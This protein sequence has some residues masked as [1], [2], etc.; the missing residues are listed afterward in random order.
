MLRCYLN[1]LLTVYSVSK[2]HFI[3]SKEPII[4]LKKGSFSDMNT[5]CQ[6]KSRGRWEN[7]GQR[8]GKFTFRLMY[9][10]YCVL[11]FNAYSSFIVIS[12]ILLLSCLGNVFHRKQ[13]Y[14]KL[15]SA[16][17]TYHLLNAN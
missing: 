9:N 6:R 11:K 1:W 5:K 4:P 8:R 12:Q 7:S 13:I 16:D 10:I 3:Q 17:F 14:V 2:L 15:R